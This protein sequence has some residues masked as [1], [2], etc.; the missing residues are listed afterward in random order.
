MTAMWFLVLTL[1]GGASA[2]SN[3]R[4]VGG[5]PTT[6]EKYPAL[7]Q[8]EVFFIH[9]WSQACAANILT[10]RYVLTYLPRFRRIRAGS[11]YR[12]ID[13]IVS[14]VDIEFNH[15]SYGQYGFDGDISVIRLLTPLVYS[16]VIQQGTIIAQGYNVP[17]NSPVVQVGWGNTS[18]S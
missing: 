6:I 13:G 4:I 17:D 5:N 15:P 3:H 18:V 1:L 12:N 2:S 16:P 8:V 7:V 10:P 9:F 14:Y 11:T